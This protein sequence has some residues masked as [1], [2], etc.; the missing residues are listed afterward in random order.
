MAVP[1]E[2]ISSAWTPDAV[3][4]L[5]AAARVEPCSGGLADVGVLLEQSYLVRVGDDALMAVRPHVHPGNQLHLELAAFASASSSP[6]TFRGFA[7]FDALCQKHGAVVG[8][9][10]TPHLTLAKAAQR[11]GFVLA[12]YVLRKTFGAH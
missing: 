9:F 2:V 1:P 12:G 10:A 4:A 6:S 7:T 3:E 8:S 5:A 11:R